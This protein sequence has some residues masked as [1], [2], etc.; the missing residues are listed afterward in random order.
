MMTRT[1]C[2][3]IQFGAAKVAQK[4]ESSC[5]FSINKVCRKHSSGIE[6]ARRRFKDIDTRLLLSYRRRQYLQAL[7]TGSAH[8]KQIDFSLLITK[9]GTASSVLF[10]LSLP[11]TS[12]SFAK[13]YRETHLDFV[14]LNKLQNY[15]RTNKI[16]VYPPCSADREPLLDLIK[17]PIGKRFCGSQQCAVS[18]EM[19]QRNRL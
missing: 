5:C 9:G 1:E 10:K 3:V 14:I 16:R 4:L 19:P 8:S 6:R 2:R 11:H 15:K 18:E 13:P 7:L 12:L 17:W